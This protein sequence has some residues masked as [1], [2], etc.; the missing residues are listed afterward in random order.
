MEKQPYVIIIDDD[1]DD[2]DLLKECFN[3]IYSFGFRAF[4][5]GSSF[6]E[7]IDQ[8]DFT[9][10]CLIIID[11]NL[12][13]IRGVDIL[14]R[15][16]SNPTLEKIPLVVFSTGGTLSELTICQ[17]AN[18]EV[19]KKPSSIREWQTM[20]SLMGSHCAPGLLQYA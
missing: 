9:N 2:V 19:F 3:N 6:L 4:F 14:Q 15:I 5:K 7:F 10:P 16:K 20:I 8:K 12:P 17:K 13:D 11:L 18:V 1:H